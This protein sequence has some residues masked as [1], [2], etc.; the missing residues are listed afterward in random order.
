MWL[1]PRASCL[2]GLGMLP[3][4]TLAGCPLSRLTSCLP[5]APWGAAARLGEV[6]SRVVRPAHELIWCPK[7]GAFGERV[8]KR[9]NPTF[10]NSL[11]LKRNSHPNLQ[12]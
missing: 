10:F 7:L 6:C 9:Q 1:A 3:C 8:A 5:R 4:E 11:A 2:V 12:P